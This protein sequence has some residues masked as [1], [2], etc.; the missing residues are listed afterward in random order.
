MPNG[1]DDFDYDA[2]EQLFAV[3][4]RERRQP[5]KRRQLV[6]PIEVEPEVTPE[7]EPEQM[8][9]LQRYL[10]MGA[11]GLG[12][13]IG[14]TPVTGAMGG[15]GSELV[16]Q[17]I[18]QGDFTPDVD[19][20]KVAAEAGVGAVGGKFVK[21]LGSLIGAP[22]K[23]ALTGGAFGAAAPILRH[24]IGE[25]E[26]NPADYPG[27][28]A[29]SA[30]LS[31]L[32]GGALAKL[33]N[34]RDTGLPQTPGQSYQVET[35]SIPGGQT[36]RTGAGQKGS[37]LVIPPRP[38]RSSEQTI[39]AAPAV[40]RAA[41][42]MSGIPYIGQ[43][44]APLPSQVQLLNK[45]AREAEVLAKAA[46][47]QRLL[48]EAQELEQK[49]LDE[50]KKLLAERGETEVRTSESLSAVDPKT[51]HRLG[52][53][54][55][56]TEAEEGGD[57]LGTLL[58][59]G[60]DAAAPVDPANKLAELQALLQKAQGDVPPVQAP[61]APLAWG[62]NMVDDASGSTLPG[63]EGTPHITAGQTLD[64]TRA[65]RDA[66]QQRF[67]EQ[68]KTVELGQDLPRAI[69]ETI[70]EAPIS[71]L[72]QVLT[73]KRAGKMKRSA[74]ETFDQKVAKILGQAEGGRVPEVPA[75]PAISGEVLPADWMEELGNSPGVA[76]FIE[77]TAP[78]VAAREA[79][80]LGTGIQSY[81]TGLEEDAADF[82]RPVGNGSTIP[83]A[84]PEASPDL[85]KQLTNLASPEAG[86]DL[87]GTKGR[88][89]RLQ[90]L[91]KAG[92]GSKDDAREAGKLLR[93]AAKQTGPATR[94]APAAGMAQEAA[95]QAAPRVAD[96][97][98]AAD[99]MAETDAE[100]ARLAS[101]PPEQRVAALMESGPPQ[102]PIGAPEAVAGPPAGISDDVPDWVQQEMAAA[103]AMK[104]AVANPEVPS[105]QQPTAE[106]IM[107]LQRL[108]AAS[109]A[110]GDP[111]DAP[112]WLRD[113][114]GTAPEAP[115]PPPVKPKAPPVSRSKRKA[116]DVGTQ[117]GKTWGSR[118]E[119]GPPNPQD[120]R[121]KIDSPVTDLK[122][123]L[124]KKPGE[125]GAVPVE[126]AARLGLGI[127]GAAIG[128]AVDPFDDPTLSAMAGFGAGAALPSVIPML[129]KLGTA[130]D[131]IRDAVSSLSTPGK[132]PEVAAKV[133]K[134]L[135][136]WQRASYLFDV[137]GLPANAW[138]GP[139]G[140]GLTGALEL[141]FSGD[142]RGWAALKELTPTAFAKE[143]YS[144]MEEAKSAIGR[145]EGYAMSQGENIPEQMLAAPGVF[146]TAGDIAIRR[147]L[148]RVG[149]P[150]DLARKLTLTSEPFTKTGEAGAHLRG[151]GWDITFPFKRT[152]INIVEQGMLRTPGVGSVM[153][154]VGAARGTRPADSLRQQAVQQGMGATLGVGA[155]QLGE[156]LD[157]ETAKLVRRYISN[158]AGPSSL[159]AGL[160]FAI[161]QARRRGEPGVL[162][163]GARALPQQLPLP[164]VEPIQDW[165]KFL[166]GD[167]ELPRG[168]Y[169]SAIDQLIEF[170]KAQQS[171]SPLVPPR[172]R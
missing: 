96:A 31:G 146:L 134:V 121:F 122:P 119:S 147:I 19:W 25:G 116:G 29:L 53:K 71:P 167:G 47:R 7:P 106:Q 26:W 155:E 72:S 61:D 21:T 50:L 40:A 74:T 98:V 10:A 152:P 63:A 14:F 54:W 57:A 124:N 43:P 110:A 137:V 145:A 162:K 161:G 102:T 32:T 24:G 33:L 112:S 109:G 37:E 59:E 45:E 101:L 129:Q 157:P 56:P 65:L 130:P 83:S 88:Y 41:D 75:A 20:R 99:W 49:K 92:T 172:R 151:L 27:E 95:A 153:Q 39:T 143:Y 148:E 62:P 158:A 67:V 105:G 60:S 159:L 85:I 165:A 30:G 117:S 84:G 113:L 66:A 120:P 38:I 135:P 17:G 104:P 69:P 140:S 1:Y 164:T 149:I 76:R 73:P 6:Q 132:I 70:P 150:E 103:E 15:A 2:L 131:V 111:S 80:P 144:A 128:G 142:P 48:Q 18:E 64:D 82:A 139:Y 133:A 91:F 171:L 114:L 28:V 34:V 170:F 97:P 126:L 160:G 4:P 55:V 136:Q 86:L 169:P 123:R 127:G 51:G 125:R 154:A 107:E 81:M 89:G 77:E 35:T 46:E 5:R 44:A 118:G 166:A 3:Q 141:G 94:A 163:A 16:A 138:V 78:D 156:N 11:R 23:A 100:I 168:A 115:V 93:Y 13:L 79:D 42:D 52:A 36:L 90:G 68:T 8:S 9:D 108:R 58:R 22:V 87:L 12:G